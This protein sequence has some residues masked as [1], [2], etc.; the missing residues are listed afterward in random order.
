MHQV[1]PLPGELAIDCLQKDDTTLLEM[2]P[3]LHA[4]YCLQESYRQNLPQLQATKI[5]PINQKVF[6]QCS[7]LLVWI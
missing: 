2:N 4:Y 6:L 1:T 7:T 5:I 3:M